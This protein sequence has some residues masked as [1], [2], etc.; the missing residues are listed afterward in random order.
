MIEKAYAAFQLNTGGIKTPGTDVFGTVVDNIIAIVLAI[1][2]ILAF[3]NLVYA[4]YMVI[5]A[6]GDAAKA[7]AG[8]KSIIM[9]IIGII[10]ISLAFIII[11]FTGSLVSDIFKV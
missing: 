2:G 3:I 4:G 10:I 8:R 5:T 6:G 11:E 7:A 9:T 1:L